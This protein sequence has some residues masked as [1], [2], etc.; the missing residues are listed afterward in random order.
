MNKQANKELLNLSKALKKEL[1]T[2]SIEYIDLL[3]YN[4]AKNHLINKKYYNS[5]W[6]CHIFFKL[7]FKIT[8]GY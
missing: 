4:R 3:A 6:Y 5:E 7:F 2:K 8:K 1:D